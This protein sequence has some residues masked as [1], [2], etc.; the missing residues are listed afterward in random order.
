M[1][2][3][4]VITNA[5]SGARS[6]TVVDTD[7]HE[8]AL[9]GA[10]VSANENAAV[11][12]IVGLDETVHRLTTPKDSQTDRVAFF[13]GLAACLERNIGI[14]KSLQLQ[15]NRVKTPKYRG[16]IAEMVY[17]LSIGEK[18]SD[19]AA[20]H[21]MAFPPEIHSLLVAG[22][23]AGQLAAVCKRIGNSQ[24]K[25]SRI[26]KKL[27][28]GMIYP[29]IVLVLGIGVV[30]AM[31]YTLV[32]A[33]KRLYESLHV[34]LPFGT[35]ALLAIS[36]VLIKQ[37]WTVLFPIGGV[38]FLFKN[39]GKIAA[40]KTAQNI[41]L[42]LPVVGNLVRKSAA[43]VSF[44]CLAMLIDAN[45]RLSQALKITA[46]SSWHWH[47]KTFFNNIADHVTVGRTLFEGF[48]TEAHWLG[49][50]SRNLC[51]LMELCAETGTGTE[52]L[53]EIA[54]D[55]EDDLDTIASQIDKILEPITILMLGG[56]VGFLVYAIYAPI[57]SIGDA[58][59]P[60]KKK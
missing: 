16:I 1:L 10:G 9:V 17:D 24:K 38:V 36:D 6:E 31:S 60:G 47:Y 58:L 40:T 32:P 26:M 33:M 25:T 48:V 57:F 5:S 4:V 39:F 30:I 46:D 55:Y 14:V 53:N 37:P 42:K 52:M 2:K 45:V 51:G 49:P 13:N 50:D 27:K 41:F 21:P 7:T 15:A 3:K 29:A 20:K 34:A 18:F 12:D 43:A 28:T 35:K 11:E 19:A 22:E 59:L 54:G 8:K 56:I 44:R 23:E